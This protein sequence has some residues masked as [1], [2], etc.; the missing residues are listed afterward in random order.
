MFLLRFG[1]W[2]AGLVIVAAIVYSL[3]K[4][5]YN[6]GEIYIF[7]AKGVEMCKRNSFC[8]FVKTPMARRSRPRFIHEIIGEYFLALRSLASPAT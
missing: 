5:V 2:I 6:V 3:I 1:A 7:S 4:S 8:Q